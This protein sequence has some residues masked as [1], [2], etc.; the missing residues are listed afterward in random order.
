MIW[1]KITQIWKAKDIRKDLLYVLAM[2][3]IFRAAAHVPIPGI[4]VT[5]LKDFFSSNQILGL[6]NIFSGGGVENFSVVMLG[7]APYITASIVLQL[8][9]M[10]VP[11]LERMSKEGEQGRQKINQYTRWLTVPL[12]VLQAYGYI[13]LIQRQ[14]QFQILGSL[15][16]QQLIISILTITAGTMFLMWIGELI[17]ERKV[18]NGI[19]L[20]IFAGIVVSLPSSLQ[21]TIAIF[22]PSQLL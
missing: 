8:L 22:D 21:R 3:I 19:S 10:I 16:T 12:A 2:L 5:G 15:S 17:S 18:G 6:L 1:E 20:L 7:I 4:D 14:S 11:A 9:T 13:T